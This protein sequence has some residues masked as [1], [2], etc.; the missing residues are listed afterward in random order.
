MTGPDHFLEALQGFLSFNTLINVVSATFVGMV[1]GALP[2]LTATMGV[3]L[4]TT[5]TYSLPADQ[6]MLVL[7]CVYV[8][9]I[10]GGS[11]SAILLNIPGTPAN[12]ATCLDGF[13]LARQGHA[14]QAM[15]L[16]TTA[17]AIG[18]LIGVFFLLLIAPTLADF[19]LRFQSY[20]YFWL[21]VFGI[22][23]A[24]LM[25]A[26]DDPLKGWIAGV[27]GLM[28]AMVGQE[29]IHAY[30]RFSFG[31]TDLA[32]GFALIPVLVG[33]FGLAEVLT[34]MRNPPAVLA[35][36]HV[37]RVIP[38]FGELWR[39]KRTIAR[40]GVIGTGVGIIPGVGEDIGAWVSYAAAKRS[41]AEA[42]KFGK[43]SI[44]G[45]IAAETG[46][47]S[48]IPGAIIPVLTLAIPGS[49]P[50]AVLLA[51]MLIHGIRPGP[52]IMQEAPQFVYGV[53]I[54]LV[55]ATL[56][57]WGLGLLLARPLLYI[58]RV[59]RHIMMPIVFVLCIIGP[60]AITQRLFDVWVMIGFGIAGF[61]LREMRFPM[62]PLVLGL[63]LGD[64][65]DKNLRRALT[66][67]D[68]D[69]TPFFT[70]PISA[71]LWIVTLFLILSAI[72]AVRRAVGRAIRRRPA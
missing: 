20:E 27:L 16:A 58:L 57:M 71:V 65:L 25:T 15:G 68:G 10:Y 66:L 30:E 37:G 29:S 60:Y 59:P 47:N 33:A 70:R 34:E 44:E 64:L 14:G 42:E 4:M 11:R 17:S 69:P 53:V 31:S 2:G 38:R 23:I 52:L 3:A 28:A 5:L 45:L 51:A 32:G 6:A 8:G 62:A 67:S 19:A 55:L 54:M 63:I 24:G 49:A 56:A 13:P 41:S 50:A 21:A 9:A 48:A 72:P 39:Y 46:N 36:T 26:A 61:L 22:V 35:T 7:I 40:S 43:G 18:T 12:A 1:I